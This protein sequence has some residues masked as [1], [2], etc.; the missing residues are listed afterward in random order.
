VEQVL[1][2]PVA[3]AC[4]FHAT[5]E[6][7]FE[8]IEL[9]REDLEAVRPKLSRL[10]REVVAR[11]AAGWYPAIPAEGCCSPTLAAACGPQPLARFLGKVSDPDLARRLALLGEPDREPGR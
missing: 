2:K 8:R 4:F 11:C 3:R 7:D 1:G 9:S 10:V 6:H 5:A